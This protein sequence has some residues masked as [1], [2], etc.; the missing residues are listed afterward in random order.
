MK[1]DSDKSE[2]PH[3]QRGRETMSNILQPAFERRRIPRLL[4]AVVCVRS[5]DGWCALRDKR[6]TAYS[7]SVETRCGMFVALPWGIE[8]RQPDCPDCKKADN[9]KADL[10]P[11]GAR[12]PR[13]GTEGGN[14]G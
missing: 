12:Q 14:G 8:R 4:H 10:P 3:K 6:K 5:R 11:T 13:S 9:E 1:S 2:R 7:D